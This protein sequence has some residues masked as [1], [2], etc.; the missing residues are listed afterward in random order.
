MREVGGSN[1][2][3][4]ILKKILILTANYG[5]G[6][7]IASEGLKELIEDEENDVEILDI[8][9]AGSKI[10]KITSKLYIFL[11]RHSHFLWRI[12]Y[13]NP[14]AKAKFFRNLLKLLLNKKVY[15]KVVNYNPDI[16]IS[17][18]FF[19]TIYGIKFK[20]EKPNTKLLVCI[21][22]YEIHP[23][24]LFDEVD[25]Y[26]LPSEFSLRTFK[27]KNFL[28]T[29]IPLRKG[30]LAKLDKNEMKKFFNVETNKFIVLLNLGA[31]SVLPLKDAIKFIDLFKD[32]LYFLIIV[33]R[34]EKIFKLIENFLNK[35]RAEYKLFG[36][37]QEIYKLMSICDFSITKAGGL[38]VSELLY[39]EKPAI[40][41]KS[42]PGQEEG[43]EKFIKEYGLGL[44]AKN[45]SQLVKLT[46][47]IIENPEILNFIKRNLSIQK[48]KMNFLE[49]KKIVSHETYAL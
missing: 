7:L 46:Q 22:D 34:D 1:P 19:A 9:E 4:P 18:H 31:N 32:K 15:D 25:L 33:G 44:I 35:I 38:S 41:Y 49:I 5:A 27:G 16:I 47:F 48:K 37:T 3:P 36:F 42:L 43:N 2:P 14:I 40:Y 24:W 30:F 28:I 13:Y 17:T 8:V 29:G 6:H 20:N 11:N 26:F 23:I 39:L 12:I 10:E 21:T 45:F